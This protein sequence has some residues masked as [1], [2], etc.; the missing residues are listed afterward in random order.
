MHAT[1]GC[2]LILVLPGYPHGHSPQQVPLYVCTPVRARSPRAPE[3]Q[4][5]RAPA[6]TPQHP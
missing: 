1:P 2:R 5:P 4:S 3:P 6:V